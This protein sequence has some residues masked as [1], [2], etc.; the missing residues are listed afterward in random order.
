MSFHNLQSIE[1]QFGELTAAGI[2]FGARGKA[3][4]WCVQI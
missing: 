1:I 4:F 2:Q 3:S